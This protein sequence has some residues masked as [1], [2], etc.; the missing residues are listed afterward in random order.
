MATATN[1]S[2]QNSPGMGWTSQIDNVYQ[3]P[4]AL[5]FYFFLWQSANSK[6]CTLLT[7]VGVGQACN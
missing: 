2:S 5:F 6:A 7:S 1:T 4:G 3:H